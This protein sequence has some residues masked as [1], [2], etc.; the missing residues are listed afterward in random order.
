RLR[1]AEL[2]KTMLIQE[3]LVHR[4]L[5]LGGALLLLLVGVGLRLLKRF[6]DLHLV[7][8]LPVL[9][10]AASRIGRGDLSSPVPTHY[11]HEFTSLASAFIRMSTRLDEARTELEGERSALAEALAQVQST[12]SEL[13]QAEK[14][15]AL[16]RMTAGLAHELNNPLATVLGYSELL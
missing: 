12:Q 14:L 5:L 15:A 4:L 16:G 9:T 13:I 2:A 7:T 11:D 6:V 10:A 3:T 8:P 1:E